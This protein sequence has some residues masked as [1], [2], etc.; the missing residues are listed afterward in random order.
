[1]QES[2]HVHM[3]RIAAE[4]IG[5]P[6]DAL[7]E[8]SS[9]AATPDRMHVLEVRDLGYHG[10][11]HE[12]CSLTHFARRVIAM[13][14]KKPVGFTMVGYCY[15]RDESA[16]HLDL[17]NRD[18]VSHVENYRWPVTPEMRLKEPLYDLLKVKGISKA[19]DEITFPAASSY[20]AWCEWCISRIPKD[21]ES[22]LEA[23]S[24]FTGW[25]CHYVQDLCV[26]HH[27]SGLLL[28]GHSAFEGDAVESWTRLRAKLTPGAV[29]P[30]SLGKQAPTFRAIAEKVAGMS[31]A[32]PNILTF[33]AQ[34][35]HPYW[36]QRV[37]SSV[38]LAL[39][40]TMLVLRHA[41]DTYLSAIHD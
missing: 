22:V 4:L 5:W 25:A 37:D 9:E 23:V 26:P 18:V 41:K 40:A 1:M 14:D 6:K 35:H 15:K 32:V 34:V 29:P 21:E 33:E 30:L 31:F 36:H 3:T 16:P 19:A 13:K 10:F 12:L 7:E 17:P 20:A 38:K 24:H 27:A 39:A 11:G 28:A 2:T 8:V